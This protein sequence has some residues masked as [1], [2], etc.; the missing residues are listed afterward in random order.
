MDDKTNKKKTTVAVT[1]E[2]MNK[3]FVVRNHLCQVNK[4]D[5]SYSSAVDF[6]I[7]Y[8]DTNNQRG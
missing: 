5:V 2:V 8:Y 6:L 7:D 1:I 3:L 4:K